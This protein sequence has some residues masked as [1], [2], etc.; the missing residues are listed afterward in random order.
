MS[1]S[2]LGQVELVK[3]LLDKGADVNAMS[4][5]VGTALM[6]ASNVDVVRL[7]LDKG[8]DVNAKWKCGYHP[9][10]LLGETALMRAAASGSVDKVKLLLDRG[11][12]IN[13]K[14]NDG[15]T[16]L[17]SATCSGRVEVIKILLVKE[18]ILGQG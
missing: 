17:L 2:F 8:A 11:A 6:R 1:A 5:G 12:D 13:T 15:E 9:A 18:R 3:L 4:E 14:S 16:A 7:L 10:C